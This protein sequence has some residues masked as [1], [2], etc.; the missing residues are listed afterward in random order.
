MHQ[1]L[2]LLQIEA[3]RGAI[4]VVH[5]WMCWKMDLD[6]CTSCMKGMAW[7]EE[8]GGNRYI[9]CKAVSDSGG[10]ETGYITNM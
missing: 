2:I 10:R 3:L 7:Q 4:S 6:Y 5:L 1:A 8:N 9:Y